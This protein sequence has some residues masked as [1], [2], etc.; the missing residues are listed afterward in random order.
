MSGDGQ[1]PLW[2][3]AALCP[4]FAAVAAAY[5]AVGLG[6]GTGYVAIMV[7]AGLPSQ[8]I[9][10]TALLLNMGVTGV[11]LC[12]YGLAGRVRPGVLAP[13]LLPAIP[14]AFVGGLCQ[15]PN[16]A[17][18]AVLAVALLLA[19]AATFRSAWRCDEEPHKPR[20]HTKLLVGIPCGALI[21]FVSGVVGI[22]GGVFAG[23]LILCLRW[24]GPKEVAA[25]NALLVFTLSAVGLLGHGLRGA[26]SMTM[27]VP[28]AVA[29]LAGGLLGAHFGEKKMSPATLQKVFAVVILVAGLKAVMDAIR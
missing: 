28:F 24:A 3:V 26:V 18:F 12:R 6:G 2:L 25:M 17:F 20:L 10:S 4:L 27:V 9:P 16:R 8:N 22:G 11:A 13:F 19:A 7:L 5:S 1:I 21:G 29:T 23:P 14:A 15:L